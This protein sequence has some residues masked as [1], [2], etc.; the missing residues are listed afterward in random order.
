MTRPAETRELREIIA[1]G[2]EPSAFATFDRGYTQANYIDNRAY[3]HAEKTVARARK[4]A[5]A[6]LAAIEASG[7]C[8]VPLEPTH[9]MVMA[10]GDVVVDFDADFKMPDSHTAAVYRAAIAARPRDAGPTEQSE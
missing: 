10:G 6:A 7:C 2:M 4:K 5:D 8:I 1:R 9:A 3:L